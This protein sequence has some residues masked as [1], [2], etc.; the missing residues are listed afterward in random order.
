[1]TYTVRC[2]LCYVIDFFPPTPGL[3]DL[4]AHKKNPLISH[5]MSR[6]QSVTSQIQLPIRRRYMVLTMV[7]T[8]RMNEG[9]L[10]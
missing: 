3:T 2:E 10:M 7:Q 8:L 5:Q 4:S 1:M 9:Y 6:E